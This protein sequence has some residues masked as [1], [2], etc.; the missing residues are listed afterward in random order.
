MNLNIFVLNYLDKQS[1]AS[2]DFTG[3]RGWVFLTNQILRDLES[4]GYFSLNQKKE[5]GVEVINSFWITIPQ[6]MRNIDKIFLPSSVSG[7][8][9]Q[10]ISEKKFSFSFVNGMIRLDQTVTKNAS[11]SVFTLSSWT[12]GT[13]K[14]ND[15]TSAASAYQDSL[16]VVTNGDLA[17]QTMYIS[18]SSASDGT[19]VTLTFLNPLGGIPATSTDGYTTD[20][21]VMLRY[22]AGFTVM[23]A[24]T[25]TLPMLDKYLNALVTGLTMLACSRN[26]DKYTKL[27]SDYNDALETLGLTEFT[28]TADQARPRPRVMPGYQSTNRHRQGF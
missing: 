20:E 6:D 10:D 17:G 18:D 27:L 7:C 25:D 4:K 12:I 19:Y 22:L 1:Q 5:I 16:L 21:F 24:Y 8:G 3:P 15:A 28:P 13:V 14:I 11:P 26:D 9:D 23:S 2:R